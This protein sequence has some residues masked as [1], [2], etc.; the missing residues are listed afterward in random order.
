V[1][2][3]LD[4]PA[5]TLLS[6][7]ESPR[8]AAGLLEIASVGCETLAEAEPQALGVTYWFDAAPS[9]EPYSATVRFVGHRL[10]LDR[11]PGSGDSFAVSETVAT[12]VPGSGRVAVTARILDVAP[13]R[14][15]VT[16]TLAAQRQPDASAVPSRTLSGGGDGSA[17]GTTGFEPVIGVRAPGAHLGVWP[18]LV[19]VGVVVALTVQSR[20]AARSHLPVTWTLWVSLVASVVGLLGARVYFLVE[21]RPGAL[22]KPREL[23]TAGMCIQGF[24]LSAMATATLGMLVAGIPVGPFLDA[25]APGL[26]FG[27]TVGRLGCFFGGCCAGR[28]TAS[29]WGVWSSDRRVGARRIPTQLLESALALALGVAALVTVLMGML[30]PAGAAF[31]GSMAA[32]TLGRQLLLPWRDLPRNTSHGRALTA[33]IAAAIVLAD[34]AVAILA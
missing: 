1:A 4:P 8:P 23:L 16:A 6:P 33:A 9:G 19:G 2:L 32:Y 18:A 11:R 7:P 13:G 25:T 34:V 3:R 21:R 14:W 27:M 20:L 31:V 17:S 12:V 29:R 5:T 30:E 22:F 10:G 15:R 28:P 24:V 26:L